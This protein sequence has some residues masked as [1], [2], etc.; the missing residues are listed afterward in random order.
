MLFADA[1]TEEF[2][3]GKE[4]KWNQC[5]YQETH[6][7]WLCLLANLDVERLLWL[8]LFHSSFTGQGSADVGSLLFLIP[9]L[10]LL[11][12]STFRDNEAS[13]CLWCGTLQKQTLLFFQ[14][15][16]PLLL[17]KMLRKTDCF[18]LLFILYPICNIII[19]FV[20][21]TQSIILTS[22]CPG[23]FYFH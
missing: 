3:L 15:Q 1:K 14:N 10:A 22:A 19:A 9:H 5:L 20:L 2:L 17:R 12:D 21:Q 23:F 18:L 8:R 6:W 13:Q 7:D 16:L 11:Y 4:T